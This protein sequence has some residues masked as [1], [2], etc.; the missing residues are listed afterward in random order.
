MI[1]ADVDDAFLLGASEYAMWTPPQPSGTCVWC[2]HSWH[3]LR[4]GHCRCT[5]AALDR[6]D[7]TWRPLLDGSNHSKALRLMAETG[8]DGWVALH[9]VSAWV[10]GLTPSPLRIRQALCG[11]WVVRGDR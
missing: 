5:S 9:A 1:I 10:P 2:N 3:G 11:D 6:R 4:C 8:C 7:D